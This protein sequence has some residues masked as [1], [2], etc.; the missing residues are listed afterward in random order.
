MSNHISN[1]NPIS[2]SHREVSVGQDH[3]LITPQGSVVKQYSYQSEFECDLAKKLLDPE[4]AR[5][6]AQEFE[7]HIAPTALGQFK[8]EN[9]LHE[10][11]EALK[12]YAPLLGADSQYMLETF[13]KYPTKTSN[14]LSTTTR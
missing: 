1:N 8:G 6:I 7:T 14:N 9:V 12:Y 3:Y 10:W 4:R 11:R 2:T 5:K 13:Q